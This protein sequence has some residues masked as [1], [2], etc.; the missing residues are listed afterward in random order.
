MPYM[1]AGFAG[2]YKRRTGSHTDG[3]ALFYKQDKL[4]LIEHRQLEYRK[5]FKVL[6]RDNVGIIA[7][8]SAT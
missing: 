3:C 8:F 5:S 6:D 4:T 1:H 7:K 2:L